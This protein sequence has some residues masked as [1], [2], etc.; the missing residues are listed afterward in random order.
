MHI[1]QVPSTDGTASDKHDD[2]NRDAN[3]YGPASSFLFV[4]LC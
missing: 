3:A 2:G 4:L 1:H